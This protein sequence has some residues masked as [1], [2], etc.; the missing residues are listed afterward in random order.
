[1]GM[2]DSFI[3]EE[4]NQFCLYPG[5]YQTKDLDCALHTF[6]VDKGN[7]IHGNIGS[8]GYGLEYITD[9]NLGEYTNGEDGSGLLEIYGPCWGPDELYGTYYLKVKDSKITEIL[10]DG[11][12]YYTP[13]NGVDPKV[14][15]GRNVIES[16]NKNRRH[17]S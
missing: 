3:L 11:E 8:P 16:R 9:I 14:R 1:M 13:E 15:W 4:G 7:T 6:K 2:F 12:V 17:D 5:E 10:F